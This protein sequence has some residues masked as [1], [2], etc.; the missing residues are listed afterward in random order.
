MR[1]NFELSDKEKFQLKMGHA[2]EIDLCVRHGVFEHEFI[3]DFD[4]QEVDKILDFIKEEKGTDFSY[5]QEYSLMQQ[6]VYHPQIKYRVK[7][8]GLSHNFSKW[9]DEM[10]EY[11]EYACRKIKR[12]WIHRDK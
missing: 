11:I 1:I 12:D 3:E 7:C 2:S 4:R 8:N 9:Y 6:V 5:C 10:L